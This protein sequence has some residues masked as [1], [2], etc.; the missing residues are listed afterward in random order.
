M[1]F[2]SNIKLKFI[3]NC[4]CSILIK[5]NINYKFVY[6]NR[7]TFVEHQKI[8][9][10]L[11]NI[12]RA[13]RPQHEPISDYYTNDELNF[14][15]RLHASNL[16]AVEYK[17]MLKLSFN[18]I[19]IVRNTEPV[20]IKCVRNHNRNKCHLFITTEKTR[21]HEKKITNAIKER[22]HKPTKKTTRSQKEKPT[23]KRMYIS[24]YFNKCSI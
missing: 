19:A 24:N 15:L 23:I 5:N 1:L 22:K 17:H 7:N 3:H 21:K 12:F 9:H 20:E 13:Q 2:Y 10:V 6:S 11:K 4:S 14:H 16:D 18:E 8:Q